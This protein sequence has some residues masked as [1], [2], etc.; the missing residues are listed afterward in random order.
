M[1]YI[2]ILALIVIII[3]C[4]LISKENFSIPS[5]VLNSLTESTFEITEK[6]EPPPNDTSE[7]KVKG[8]LEQSNIPETGI[9]LGK[10]NVETREQNFEVED[11]KCKSIKFCENLRSNMNCGYCLQDD[12]EGYHAFHYGDEDG[13][14]LK[15]N[16][17][18]Q[19]LCKRGVDR[20]G[21]E[22]W[23]PPSSLN[24]EK[25][26]QLE[27]EEEFYKKRYPSPSDPRRLTGLRKIQEKK[28]NLGIKDTGYSGCAKMR[29]RYVCSKVNDCSPMNFEMFGI[30]AKDICGFCADDGKAYVRNDLP[31]SSKSYEST[32]YVSRTKCENIEIFGDGIDC[33]KYSNNKDKC[34][35][36]KSLEDPSI[37]ACAFNY[38]MKE[39]KYPI[40]IPLPSEVKYSQGPKSRVYDKCESKW[41]LIRPNQC[42]FFEQQ[43]PC[44]KTK[45]GGPHSE[46]CLE[47]LWK[48]MGFLTSYRELYNNGEG[49]MVNSWNKM[50]V[51]SIME[52]MQKIYEKIY[53]SDYDVAK[54]WAK[55][56]FNMN[57]N[58]CNRA[59]LLNDKNPSQ[60]WKTT[61]DPCM[62]KLY[63]YG[64]GKEDGLANP[65]NKNKW[66]YGYFGSLKEGLTPIPNDLRENQTEHE[67]Y[68]SS[69]SRN[70]MEI[71]KFSKFKTHRDYINSIRDLV[72]MKNMSDEEAK[73][74]PLT[75]HQNNWGKKKFSNANW[76]DKYTATKLITGETPDYP[77][78]DTKPCWPEFARMMLT[79]P[80]IKLLNLKTLDFSSAG[81][82]HFLSEKRYYSLRDRNLRK[83]G[84]SV[85]EGNYLITQDTYDL[86][87]FPY[88]KFISVGNEYWKKR[89]DQFKKILVDYSDTELTTYQ[90]IVR[91]T[92]ENEAKEI[93]KAYG[94]R[95]GGSSPFAGNWRTKG[96]YLVRAGRENG[97]CYFGRGGSSSR[98]RTNLSYP[99]TRVD[100]NNNQE[101]LRFLPNSRFYDILPATNN[102]RKCWKEPFLFEYTN[103]NNKKVRILFSSAYKK[104]EKFPYY[105]FLKVTVKN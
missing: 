74:V 97:V 94:Y 86:E 55:I 90:K 66:G 96:L 17:G 52:S 103:K 9:S 77:V 19:S 63:K 29:E 28:N 46:K 98:S 102:I 15:R 51:D 31:P 36:Q 14:F 40:T 84:E 76:V 27:Q 38:D 56:C 80:H 65:K 73:K 101:V 88:W 78:D 69:Y 32:K 60:Y 2:Y 91:P 57:V 105:S 16:G 10:K 68:G 22:E 64:G 85:F 62:E 37:N 33:S 18:R 11:E 75:I 25:Q 83:Q 95:V 50:D 41:G 47:S 20:S 61:P 43:Y 39:V 7:K 6:T 54:K 44:L 13:P 42:D 21:S 23:V 82:F 24:G 1:K 92:D 89:W 59:G 87:T 35:A 67:I 71:F 30:K 81:K 100:W 53:S 79:H 49:E 99:H 3:I 12:L 8:M 34:L 26:E 48:Q 5:S 72:K 58:D 45:S 4:C 70:P 93:A 104:V